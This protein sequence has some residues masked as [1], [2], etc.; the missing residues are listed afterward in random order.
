MRQAQHDEGPRQREQATKLQAGTALWIRPE[1]QRGQPVDSRVLDASYH[2]WP[3]AYRHVE[4]EL[5]DGARAAE[6]LEEVAMQVAA[7]L[8]L[9]PAVARNLSGYLIT[10]F[11]H[12][13]R[14]ERLRDRRLSYEGLLPE[15]DWLENVP[16]ET[17]EAP[18]APF[19]LID[20]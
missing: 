15:L 1:D 20:L 13:L 6:L 9:E 5:R 10:A 8:Q 14:G 16:R 11:H 2:L 17:L 4:R 7:R 3:W 19:Q 18:A 12:R